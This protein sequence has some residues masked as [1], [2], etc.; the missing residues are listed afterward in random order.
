MLEAVLARLGDRDGGPPVLAA[1]EAVGASAAAGNRAG[2]VGDLG[3][4]LLLGELCAGGFAPF[5]FGD[6]SLPNVALLVEINDALLDFL[7]GPASFLV[8]FTSVVLVGVSGLV[9]V[10]ELGVLGVLGVRGTVGDLGAI[11]EGDVLI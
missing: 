4:V 7:V 6:A 2:R 5:V 1:D 11:L 8:S 10:L 9:V 3:L